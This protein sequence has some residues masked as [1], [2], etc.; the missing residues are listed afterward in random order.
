MRNKNKFILSLFLSFLLIFSNLAFVY[1]ED[2]IVNDTSQPKVEEIKV[3]EQKQEEPKEVEEKTEE[4]VEEK[5]EEKIE[6]EI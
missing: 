1:A 4:K 2:E 6:E 3:E 5:V